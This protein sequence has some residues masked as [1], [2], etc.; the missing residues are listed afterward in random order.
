M[1]LGKA[2]PWCGLASFRYITHVH[3]PVETAQSG[4]PESL[5]SSIIEL[6]ST[7]IYVYPIVETKM[8]RS[9]HEVCHYPDPA[10]INNVI[11]SSCISHS[12]LEETQVCRSQSASICHLAA[13]V[14]NSGPAKSSHQ[15][16]YLGVHRLNNC[17]ASRERSRR[18]LCGDDRRLC[19]S[20]STSARKTCATISAHRYTAWVNTV[21][22]R[23]GRWA[24]VCRVAVHGS[25][26]GAVLE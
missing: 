8:H 2:H 26:R 11:I 6:I 12:F 25:R 17:P 20:Y 14:S 7:L 22:S 16:C 18:V 3:S 15:T 19:G 4:W 1:A 21:R 13:H 23:T 24:R 5:P 10:L 9:L